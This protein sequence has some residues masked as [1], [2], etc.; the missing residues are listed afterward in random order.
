MSMVNDIS[1]G[2]KDNEEECLAHAEV[3]SLYARKF[4]TGQWSFIGPGSEKKWYSM[5]ET[6]HKESGT[7]SRKRCC[8]NSPKA[9][10]RFSVQ[11]P[12]LS[13][14]KLKSKG[15]GKLSIHF[16]ATQE[17]IETIFRIIVSANQ[18]SLY[19][20]VA[21]MC[22]EYESLHDRSGRLD[23]VMGQS[24]VLSVIKTEVPMDSDDPANQDL[25]LQ[26]YE[27]R[28]E[29]LS[30]QDKLSKFCMDS[31]FLSVVEIGQY[32]MTKDTGDFTQFHTVACR[33]CTLPREDGSSQPIGWVQGN[34]QIGP[35]LEVTTKLLAW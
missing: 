23:K 24:I 4:G 30:Q 13:R 2:T 3:I 7:I 14:G 15:H 11:R 5:K 12:P 25:L 20:A 22:E 29:R 16:G 9:D 19:G 18:L 26:Q 33:E 28:I 35:V 6:V 34:T 8:W 17:T 21:Q 27:E 32:F 31:E 10:A 1:C